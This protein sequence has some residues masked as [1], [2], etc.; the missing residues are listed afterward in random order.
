MATSTFA[1][2]S[3]TGMDTQ[4]EANNRSENSWRI[5]TK[6]L[7][8]LYLEDVP[9][10]LERNLAEA[11]KRFA[12]AAYGPSTLFAFAHLNGMG[13]L[14]P[15]DGRGTAVANGAAKE[16]SE[17][18][19][20]DFGGIKLT[21]EGEGSPRSVVPAP[22]PTTAG[23]PTGLEGWDLFDPV[24]E[25]RRQGVV[26]WTVDPQW[27]N[28]AGNGSSSGGDG[29]GGGT[30]TSCPWRLTAAN[31]SYSMS[32]T[33]PAVFAIPKR[34]DDQTLAQVGRSFIVEQRVKPNNTSRL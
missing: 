4:P 28:G 18:V 16:F 6:D 34:V 32:E 9:L 30:S 29:G 27:G 25:Y 5:G 33:Y 3:Q 2:E 7:R 22:I 8:L 21:A 20:D 26:E 17:E 10:N 24:A 19:D 11:F 15:P 1:P 12:N 23:A 13:D 14:P 31:R